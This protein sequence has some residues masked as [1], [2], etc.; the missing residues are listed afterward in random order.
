[1][2][3]A[4]RAEVD[5]AYWAVCVA[6]GLALLVACF[7]PGIEIGRSA[8]FDASGTTRSVVVHRTLTLATD[9]GPGAFI[10]F[11]GAA[12]LLAAGVYG[13]VRGSSPQLSL[14]P[15]LVVIVGLW[16]GLAAESHT[17]S[18]LHGMFGC[19]EGTPAQCQ[20]DFLHPAIADL[21]GE[22]V[23]RYGGR[24]EFQIEVSSYSAGTRAGW[25]LLLLTLGLLAPL[26]VFRVL[27][28]KMK[29]WVAAVATAATMFVG[30]FLVFV[31]SFPS[32]G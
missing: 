15:L 18:S 21:D 26:A 3:A 7:L 25:D 31:T 28:Y 1:M 11:I 32:E 17:W 6:A 8:S 2:D 10:Y 14:V 19:N 22:L 4:W 23:R 16:Y 12:V 29:E 20:G 13:L 24:P 27:L 9:G 5:R 30:L